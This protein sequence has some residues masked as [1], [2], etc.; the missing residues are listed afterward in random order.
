MHSY[1]TWDIFGSPAPV[2]QRSACETGPA[3][4]GRK[5]HSIKRN[6]MDE[7][8]EKRRTMTILT[9]QQGD[10]HGPGKGWGLEPL[11]T[12]KVGLSPKDSRMSGKVV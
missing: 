2:I 1:F 6:D 3:E 7:F 10:L 11:S 4:G 5:N 9:Q 8:D 12:F